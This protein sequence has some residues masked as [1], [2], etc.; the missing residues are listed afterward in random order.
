MNK[1]QPLKSIK[2]SIICSLIFNT[3]TTQAHITEPLII[4]RI[5][6]TGQSINS[7]DDD[8]IISY[9]I[10][11][12]E[13]EEMEDGKILPTMCY[14]LDKENMYFE[15]QERICQKLQNILAEYK[16]A[17]E[18][19]K[20]EISTLMAGKIHQ[21]YGANQ[22]SIE[23]A[24]EN[25]KQAMQSE[26]KSIATK[27]TFQLGLLYFY[28]QNNPEKGIPY[29]KKASYDAYASAQYELGVIYNNGFFSRNKTW[30]QSYKS[31]DHYF[32]LAADNNKSTDKELKK[33]AIYQRGKIMLE[34]SGD[35]NMQEPIKNG[36]F[37]IKKASE[38][39]HIRANHYLGMLYYAK[40]INTNKEFYLHQDHEKAIRF[41]EK[42][43]Y[44]KE[45]YNQKLGKKIIKNSDSI[46]ML[47]LL[48][49][50]P[51]LPETPDSETA[52]KFYLKAIKEDGNPK[53]ALKLALM[54]ST[55]KW[56]KTDPEV[57]KAKFASISDL[58][59]LAS[60]T[61]KGKHILG[62]MYFLGDKGGK[63]K[64]KL[65]QDKKEG[66]KLYKQAAMEGL[67]ASQYDL[68]KYYFNNR[69]YLEGYIW[70]S[71][72]LNK[73][74]RNIKTKNKAKA[75]EIH[76]KSLKEI[77]LKQEIADLQIKSILQEIARSKQQS[78][79]I[80]ISTNNAAGKPQ[81]F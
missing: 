50:K 60:K 18:K 35:L 28:E 59:L 17:A 67:K 73:N 54:Y 48:H 3:I 71:I 21:Y 45:K 74:N 30:V 55:D 66:L 9:E 32:A 79:Q 64:F 7:S 14:K 39:D 70:T 37:L 76:E 58:L 53:A 46:Y 38:Q 33:D 52:E 36:L 44:L 27:A 57:D 75:E 29:L 78:N 5:Y 41:F 47:G 8:Q 23:K 77:G 12:T 61:K 19:S 22:D 4:E 26:E 81:Y 15:H 10:L 72:F 31:A 13:E 42:A 2:L 49:E 1:T 43:N 56:V 51:L 25:Y 34:H 20:N 68:A 69:Q 40:H 24:E 80:K 16:E 62:R 65:K 63:F 11:Q 6:N